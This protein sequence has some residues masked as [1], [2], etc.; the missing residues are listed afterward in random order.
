[1]Q[2]KARGADIRMVYSAADAIRLAQENPARETVFFAIGF[3]TTA[4]ATALAI[5]TAERLR[6]TNFSVFC[7]HVLTPPAMAAILDSQ[8]GC[9]QPS[10][11]IDG[12]VGPGHVSCVIG[13]SAYEQVAEK[14][15]LPVVITGFEPLDVMQA[16][17]MLLRQVNQNRGEVENEYVRAVTRRGNARAQALMAQVFERRDSFE[18]RGLGEIARSAYRIKPQYQRFDAERRWGMEYRPV[19]DNK[20]CECAAILRGAKEPGECRAFD[21]GCTPLNPLG[22]CMVSSEGACAAYYSYGRF[23]EAGVRKWVAAA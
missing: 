23:R 9:G 18:W 2:A 6:L 14:Y 19:P 10:A 15:R 5:C 13:S 7:N 8:Q 20:A 16:V 11:G 22:A 17:L 12:V 3:E 21:K 1:M 4:P